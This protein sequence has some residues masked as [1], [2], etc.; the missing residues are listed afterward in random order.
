MSN[1]SA[2]AIALTGMVS[3]IFFMVA[4][5]NTDAKD[6]FDSAVKKFDND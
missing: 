2:I 4:A 1:L 5:L 6:L 3:I